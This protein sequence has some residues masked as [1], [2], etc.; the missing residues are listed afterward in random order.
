MRVSIRIIDQVPQLL[1]IASGH[2][3]ALAM[4]EGEDVIARSAVRH[5]EAIS[6]RGFSMLSCSLIFVIARKGASPDEAISY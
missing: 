5:D 1:E 2:S 6:L 3:V 4:T